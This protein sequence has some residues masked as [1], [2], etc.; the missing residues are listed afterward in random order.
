MFWKRG[1]GKDLGS[2][3]VKERYQRGR[4]SVDVKC[5]WGVDYRLNQ[6]IQDGK[7]RYLTWHVSDLFDLETIS[8]HP[9]YTFQVSYRGL[10]ELIRH[11]R[12]PFEAVPR[13]IALYLVQTQI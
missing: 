8:N 9:T 12:S 13:L 11:N 4:G 7:C 5:R 2:G 6:G 1:K 3:S 10:A